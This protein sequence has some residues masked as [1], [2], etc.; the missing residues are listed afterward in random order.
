MEFTIELLKAL[1]LL[2]TGGGLHW[3]VNFRQKRQREQTALAVAEYKDV[4]EMIQKATVKVMELSSKLLKMKQELLETKQML[5]SAEA[6]L[7][8]QDNTIERFKKACTCG[9]HELL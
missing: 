4:D 7:R 6:R 5:Y 2:L 8:Q 3:I 1:G 9:A